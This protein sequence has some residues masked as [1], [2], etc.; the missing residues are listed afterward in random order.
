M[1]GSLLKIGKTVGEKLLKKDDKPSGAKITAVVV[2]GAGLIG[3][4]LVSLGASPEL[5][6][7]IEE[8]VKAVGLIAVDVPVE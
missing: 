4:V 6:Q 1:L 3:A 5:A 2:A 7:A 8:F